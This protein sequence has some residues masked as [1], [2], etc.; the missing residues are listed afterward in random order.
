MIVSYLE[1]QSVINQASNYTLKRLVY[2]KQVNK[3]KS[4]CDKQIVSSNLNNVAP[5]VVHGIIILKASPQKTVQNSKGKFIE[6]VV[7]WKN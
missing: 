5:G 1:A 7:T 6:L 2:R 3:L 4:L